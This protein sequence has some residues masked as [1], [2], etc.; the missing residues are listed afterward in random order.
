MGKSGLDTSPRSPA[1]NLHGHTCKMGKIWERIVFHSCP[2]QSPTGEH[3]KNDENKNS[4]PQ[5][6]TRAQRGQIQTGQNGL[7][8]VRM[9][10]W[11]A[12][13]GRTANTPEGCLLFGPPETANSKHP[14]FYIKDLLM[15]LVINVRVFAVCC[16]RGAEQQTP[17]RGVCCPPRESPPKVHSDLFQSILTSLNLT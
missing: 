14:I 12:L 8:R 4:G 17:P 3:D 2:L 7:K 15:V 13:P 10:Y 9:H 11:G 1:K 6:C 5:N 16:L